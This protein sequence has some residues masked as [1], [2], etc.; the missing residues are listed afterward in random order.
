MKYIEEY[1]PGLQENGLNSNVAVDFSGATSFKLPA[2]TT[3]GTGTI[4][5]SSSNA[6][7]VG[8]NGAT[9]PSFDVDASTASA[10]TGV[11]VKSAAAAGGVAVSTISSGTNE[12]ITLDAKGTGTITLN[13]TATGNVIAGADV[14]PAAG[15]RFVPDAGA[16]TSTAGAAT[17][18]KQAGQITTESLTTSAGSTYTMTLTNSLIA[19][20]S[21]VLAS[22]GT[23][24][25]TTGVPTVT[26]VT[27][28]SGSAV[29]I[30]QNI[31]AT[32]ALNGTITINFVVFN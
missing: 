16:A 17:I 13:G 2:V 19:A 23:G 10:A 15:K 22:V 30:I 21:T 28:A 27:P 9:N 8:P 4:K 14:A 24:T 1:L 32:A 29:I 6:L 5:S 3:L 31:H 20:T 25:A 18:N 7:A 26:W 11:K 12:S